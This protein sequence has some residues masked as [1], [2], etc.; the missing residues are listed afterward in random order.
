MQFVSLFKRVFYARVLQSIPRAASSGPASRARHNGSIQSIQQIIR[1]LVDEGI[2]KEIDF[3]VNKVHIVN[4]PPDEIPRV[5]NNDDQIFLDPGNH[6]KTI[7]DCVK[8]LERNQVVGINFGHIEETPRGSGKYTICHGIFGIDKGLRLSQDTVSEI[9]SR[10]GKGFHFNM[11]ATAKRNPHSNH[12][13]FILV[14]TPD[15]KPEKR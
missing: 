8:K 1:S 13:S 10:V 14:L 4:V 6:A 9:S 11:E 3:N 2:L 7:D 5:V 15:T 12:W